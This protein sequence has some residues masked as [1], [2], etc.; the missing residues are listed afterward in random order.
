M[1]IACSFCVYSVDLEVWSKL[2]KRSHIKRIASKI[3]RGF[4]CGLQRV[5]AFSHCVT[6]TCV[7]LPQIISYSVWGLVVMEYIEIYIYNVMC[8]QI[9]IKAENLTNSF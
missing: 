8:H 4:E 3:A 2:A 5:N 7:L 6:L 9:N 1:K